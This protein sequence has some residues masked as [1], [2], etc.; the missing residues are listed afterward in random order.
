MPATVW[1]ATAM[2]W[3]PA[4]A[5]RPSPSTHQE[6]GEE[7]GNLPD[8]TAPRV[9]SSA[10]IGFQ[11]QQ[12]RNHHKFNQNQR[13][14]FQ[15]CAF[16]AWPCQSKR[17]STS[18][19]TYLLLPI[20]SA[21]ASQSLMLLFQTPHPPGQTAKRFSSRSFLVPT[22]CKSLSIAAATPNPGATND[23]HLFNYAGIT[24]KFWRNR[25]T[26]SENNI[27]L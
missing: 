12:R 20:N 7:A 10:M 15:P 14:A 21:L 2:R 11:P 18:L 27:T 16:L 26:Q 4:S 6:Y 1:L 8:R 17:T 9:A 25:R 22:V 13:H 5:R 3:C 19:M 24:Q 23:F